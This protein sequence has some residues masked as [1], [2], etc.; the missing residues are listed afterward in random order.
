M[1]KEFIQQ[2]DGYA[3]IAKEQEIATKLGN[4]HQA[5]RG[6]AQRLLNR[7]HPSRLDLDRSHP[8]ADQ[9][10][11]VPRRRRGREEGEDHQG[12]EGAGV[13]RCWSAA[14]RGSC[15]GVCQ[16]ESPTSVPG[17]EAV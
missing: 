13:A 6:N 10:D 5:E 17:R 8:V 9:E 15:G 2:F 14:S 3:E 12:A 16:H 1:K 11:D 4:D 7:L